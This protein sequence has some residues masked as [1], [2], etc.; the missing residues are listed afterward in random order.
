M[1]PAR[2]RRRSMPTPSRTSPP[3]SPS[4]RR[5]SSSSAT[6]CSANSGCPPLLHAGIGR[7]GTLLQRALLPELPSQ[8]W[9]RQAARRR[10]DAVDV[11][12]PRRSAKHRAG[13]AGRCRVPASQ[14]SRP[15]LRRA[16]AGVRR[17]RPGGGRQHAG[18]LRRGA[19]PLR[20]RR[21]RLP[22][23]PRIF[24]RR[25]CLWA[26]RRRHDTVSAHR[27][28]DDRD[29]ADR[30]HSGGD[31]LAHADP[32]DADGDGISGRPA[33]VRD[34]RNDE[35]VLGRFGWKAQNGSIRDQAAS[36]F[37]GDIGISTPDVPRS[38]GDCTERQPA[39][40]AM[41]DGVQPRLGD[42]EAPI[43]SWIW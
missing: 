8:G 18:L 1:G 38:H 42:T 28:S 4:R 36:A 34:H 41:P 20:R 15:R 43:L 39:C 35:I 9:T 31:I 26:T 13:T 16:A 25:P 19:V 10:R 37:A 33:I 3:T 23:P 24:C 14:R 29:G 11:P 6:R 22:A 21:N 17:A 7:T 32:D 2:R 30:S 27:Q 40:I 5:S 12:A